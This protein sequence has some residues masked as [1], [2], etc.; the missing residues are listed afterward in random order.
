M[1]MYIYGFTVGPH[2]SRPKD[3]EQLVNWM[4]LKTVTMALRRNYTLKIIIRRFK[5]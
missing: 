4:P 1:H 2:L 5:T 3:L